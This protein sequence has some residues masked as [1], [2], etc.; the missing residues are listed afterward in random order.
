MLEIKK[1]NENAIIPDIDPQRPTSIPLYACLAYTNILAPGQKL[2]IPTGLAIVI[3]SGYRGFVFAYSDTHKP[4]GSQLINTT[5]TIVS[6]PENEISV[7]VYND[8]NLPRSI[9]P[10]QKIAELVIIKLETPEV[11]ILE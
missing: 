10:G 7:P 4:T 1:I 8:S 9:E 2:E 5:S 11:Q 3:K 6:H